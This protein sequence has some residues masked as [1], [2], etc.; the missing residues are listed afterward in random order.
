MKLG[1]PLHAPDNW[2]RQLAAGGG[3]GFKTEHRHR[4]MKFG[5]SP[6]IPDNWGRQLAA[7]GS[8]GNRTPV[9]KPRGRTFFV[10]SLLFKI[11]FGRRQ[12]TA[13]ALG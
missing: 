4:G 7:G 6:H 8:E 3:V 12:Q 1:I 13:Y 5:T 11:P 9:R 10:G 2:E